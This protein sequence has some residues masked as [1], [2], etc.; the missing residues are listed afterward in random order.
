[1]SFWK[2]DSFN[3]IDDNLCNLQLLDKIISRYESVSDGERERET[4]N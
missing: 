2:K 1:M 3:V 4:L